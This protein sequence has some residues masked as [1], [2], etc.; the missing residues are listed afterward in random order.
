MAEYVFESV[1]EGASEQL[2]EYHREIYRVWYELADDGRPD[3]AQFDILDFWAWVGNLHLVEVYTDDIVYRVYGSNVADAMN[4]E[5]SRQRMSEVREDALSQILPWYRR[6]V[7]KGA[8][9]HQVIDS[10][11]VDRPL[12]W[13]R[14]FMPMTWRGGAAEMVLVHCRTVMREDSA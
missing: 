11:A 8:A 9:H 3:Y 14:L 7:D 6:V 13:S 4:W 1:P 2:P 10:I 5:W 12:R